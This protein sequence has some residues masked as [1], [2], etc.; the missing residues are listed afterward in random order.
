MIAIKSILVLTNNILAERDFEMKVLSL[1]IEIYVSKN[2][3]DQ[4]LYDGNAVALLPYFDAIIFSESLNDREVE[5][6][7]SC[8]RNSRALIKRT[9][10]IRK[11][12]PTENRKIK[13]LF[14]EYGLEIWMRPDIGLS[15]L[16]ED[17]CRHFD[18]PISSSRIANI[19]SMAVYRGEP[20]LSN[21]SYENGGYREQLERTLS[22]Q[23]RIFLNLLLEQKTESTSKKALV[24]CIWPDAEMGSKNAQLSILVRNLKEKIRYSGFFD[25]SITTIR[26]VGYRVEKNFYRIVTGWQ[27]GDSAD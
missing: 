27:D 21:I 19:E 5:R 18:C 9:T 8:I 12:L 11:D 22:N 4:L 3:V 14:F 13:R 20:I 25:S 6:L 2:L 26:G 7:L 23:E 10:L 1:N 15:D 16:R 24:N 17:L